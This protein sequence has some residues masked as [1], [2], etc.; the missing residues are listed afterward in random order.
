MIFL[1]GLIGL[2]AV[3]PSVILGGNGGGARGM[4]DHEV[5][6]YDVVCAYAVIYLIVQISQK[7]RIHSRPEPW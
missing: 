1:Q 7:R 5:M 3:W 4:K 2:V 6:S